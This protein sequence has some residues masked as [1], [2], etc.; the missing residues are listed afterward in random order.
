ML[1]IGANYGR[2]VGRGAAAARIKGIPFFLGIIEAIPSRWILIEE[3]MRLNHIS[4]ESYRIFP[5]AV[6]NKDAQV[7]FHVAYPEGNQFVTNWRGQ[8]ILKNQNIAVTPLNQKLRGYQVYQT[9]DKHHVVKVP[10]RRLSAIL[11]EVPFSS[12]DL[13]DFDVQGVEYDTIQEAI[14]VLNKRVKCLHIGTHGR[15]IEKKLKALL[16]SH[17]WRLERDYCNKA[18]HETEYGKIKFCD[19]IQTWKNTRF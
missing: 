15:D 10:Q 8:S 13:C 19:G 11:D 2:W 12:I 3:N 1:E 9:K 17:Q 6:G 4:S 18:E 5:C 7:F 14:D 16:L